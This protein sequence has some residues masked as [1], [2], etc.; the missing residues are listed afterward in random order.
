[1]R[2]NID[3]NIINIGRNMLPSSHIIYIF[4]CQLDELKRVDE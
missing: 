3:N 4:K 2:I 1:M